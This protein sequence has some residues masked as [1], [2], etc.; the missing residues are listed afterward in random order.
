MQLK[1][2]PLRNCYCADVKYEN[3]NDPDQIAEIGL[4][5]YRR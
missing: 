2:E 3:R 4:I 5:V 1:M